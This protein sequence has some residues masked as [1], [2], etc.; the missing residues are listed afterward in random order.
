MQMGGKKH[1]EEKAPARDDDLTYSLTFKDV[2]D[3][4]EVIDRSEGKELNL[5]VGDL[6]LNVIKR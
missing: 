3:I 5:E 2:V 1:G 6:K 4:L